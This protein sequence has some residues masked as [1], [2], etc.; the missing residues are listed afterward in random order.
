MLAGLPEAEILELGEHGIRPVAW[1]ELELVDHWRQFL[2]R[3]D[4]YL[5][6]LLPDEQG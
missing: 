6:H 3:P 1:Y 4:S 5:R 2:N